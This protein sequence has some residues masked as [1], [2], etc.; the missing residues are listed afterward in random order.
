MI[1]EGKYIILEG[2]QIGHVLE[3]LYDMG[4]VWNSRYIDNVGEL[5]SK[6]GNRIFLHS[7]KIFLEFNTDFEIDEY[8]L[9]RERLDI[10]IFYR[11]EKLK[12]ILK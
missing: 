10:N 4:Y 9:S 6:F 1:L 7:N 12:R 3:K 5:L 8:I 2:K 11:Y